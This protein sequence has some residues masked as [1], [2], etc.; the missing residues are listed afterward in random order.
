M[1]QPL[2]PAIELLASFGDDPLRLGAPSGDGW[3]TLAEAATRAEEWSP[4]LVEQVGDR[5]A[6]ASYLATWL[7]EAP[8]LV[9]GLCAVLGEV[10]PRATADRLWLHRHPDGWFDRH[11]VDPVEVHTGPVDEVL[12][13]AGTHVAGLTA[14]I[15]D[16]VCASLPVG[17]TAVWGSVADALS[18]YALHVARGSGRDEVE[19]WRRC[20]VLVDALQSHTPRMRRRPR[21]FP[22]TWSGGTAQYQVRG[23]CCLTY[24]TCEQPDPAT[25]ATARPVRCAPTTAA[26]G[27]CAPTSRPRPD[28]A[29]RHAPAPPIGPR[30]A[31]PV[32][33]PVSRRAAAGGS[34]SRGRGRR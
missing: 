9:V 29:C 33:G 14:P 18:G 20:E 22:V 2:E 19:T 28:W 17:P 34:R 13:A 16:L 26:P 8:I 25:T 30:S 11:A 5:R 1:S 6:A 12:G 21:L 15:V 31:T 10:A 24:R 32:A 4:A 23:T 27:G 3:W 7:A